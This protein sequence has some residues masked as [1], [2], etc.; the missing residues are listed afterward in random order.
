M[1]STRSPLVLPWWTLRFAGRYWLPLLLWFWAGRLA[2]DLLMRGA[3]AAGSLNKLAGLAVVSLAVLA[4]LSA[5]VLMLHVVRPESAD[6][7]G[8][9]EPAEPAEPAGGH[10]HAGAGRERPLDVITRTLLPFVILYGAWGLYLEDLAYLLYEHMDAGTIE[11]LVYAHTAPL[12]AVVLGSLILGTLCGKRYRR[13]GGRAFGVLSALFEANS[14]FFAFYSIRRVLLDIGDWFTSRAVWAAAAE[15][16]HTLAAP[17][18]ALLAVLSLPPLSVLVGWLWDLVPLALNG[19]ALPLLWLAVAATAH[20]G[21][22]AYRHG[23][24]PHTPTA[25]RRTAVQHWAQLGI[26]AF[27]HEIQ[28]KYKPLADGVRLALRADLITFGV[29][30]ACFVGIELITGWGFVDVTGLVGPHERAF[31]SFWDGVLVRVGGMVTEVLRVCLLAAMVQLALR[32]V[33]DRIAGTEATHR[34]SP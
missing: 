16:M 21:T 29:F 31:W 13:T 15:M 2:Y 18:N 14:L 22:G 25:V 32:R 6:R 24:A 20:S 4:S 19:L 26:E 12:I 27:S 23:T 17:I 30:C 8:P 1:D 5:T 34:P 11:Q 33:S 7:T 9:A 10:P 28:Q 3:A